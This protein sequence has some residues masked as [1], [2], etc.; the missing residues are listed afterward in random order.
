MLVP[1]L[2]KNFKSP[3]PLTSFHNLCLIASLQFKK[4]S[5]EL[6]MFPHWLVPHFV[7]INYGTSIILQVVAS[8]SWDIAASRRVLQQ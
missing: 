5:K 1:K 6:P 2:H 3:P 4:A 8:P 7:E